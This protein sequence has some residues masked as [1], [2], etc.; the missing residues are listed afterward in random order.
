MYFTP[1]FM[2]YLYSCLLGLVKNLSFEERVAISI[3]VAFVHHMYDKISYFSIN[4]NF[5]LEIWIMVVRH[6]SCNAI[7]LRSFYSISCHSKIGLKVAM[8]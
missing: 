4:H 2:S 5:S 7:G 8:L 1:C 3:K 6:T